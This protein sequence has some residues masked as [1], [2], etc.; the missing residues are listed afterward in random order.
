MLDI[1]KEKILKA[2]K[3]T[4][5]EEHYPHISSYLYPVS[6]GT[7]TPECFFGCLER[8]T[9]YI[10]IQ[11]V[12]RPTDSRPYTPI[13][14]GSYFTQ[15]Q[16]FCE[17]K[18]GNELKEIDDFFCKKIKTKIELRDNNKSWFAESIS[19]RGR[20]TEIF[21]NGIEVAQLNIIEKMG[22]ISLKKEKKLISIGLDRIIQSSC[23]QSKEMILPSIRDCSPYFTE[24]SLKYFDNFLLDTNNITDKSINIINDDIKKLS[25]YSDLDIK[26]FDSISKISLIV[27]ILY[28]KK[29]IS[30]LLRRKYIL[31]LRSF[32]EKIANNFLS[33]KQKQKPINHTFF[34][35]PSKN[36]DVN[37]KKIIHQDIG[38]TSQMI[39][40]KLAPEYSRE[41]TIELYGNLVDDFIDEVA[42]KKNK[43]RNLNESNE[44][45]NLLLYDLSFGKTALIRFSSNTFSLS[46]RISE[47]IDLTRSSLSYLN[48]ILSKNESTPKNITKD[49]KLFCKKIDVYFC[50]YGFFTCRSFPELFDQVRRLY[51]SSFH[52]DDRELIELAKL[53]VPKEREDI[54]NNN[55]RLSTRLVFV[56][57]IMVECVDLIN[58]YDIKK[59]GSRDPYKF[60]KRI[61]FMKSMINSNP[62]IQ[63]AFNDLV[64]W[65]KTEKNGES[66]FSVL[67]PL[68]KTA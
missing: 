66:P 29:K 56:V 26:N 53:S 15:L 8:N 24:N 39:G 27:E 2:V 41:K 45:K 23:F 57:I 46:L 25:E 7:L 44:L 6:S 58:I 20:G 31:T 10:R 36:K 54:D 43:T 21:S 47:I 38:L 17:N 12:F 59:I 62:L 4:I 60:K 18:P 40:E 19:C 16:I 63:T 35:P 1:Y 55:F 33:K 52:H 32:Y 14:H 50:N 67:S 51:I 42:P 9:T 22:G 30:N 68:I 34:K 61:N 64:S 28:S 48:D 49:I 5:D 13:T 3:N 37:A 11:P 65:K